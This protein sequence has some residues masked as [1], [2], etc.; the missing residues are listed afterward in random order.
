[1]EINKEYLRQLDRVRSG[2]I[3]LI[4]KKR[5]KKLWKKRGVTSSWCPELNSYYWYSYYM[6][7]PKD[8]SKSVTM[9]R[10]DY[11]YFTMDLEDLS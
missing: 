9:G 3:R 8:S 6:G 4:S 5:A 1:M 2:E 10:K 7:D 11:M